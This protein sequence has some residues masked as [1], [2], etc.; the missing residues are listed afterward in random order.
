MATRVSPVQQ[1]TK[2]MK[3][4]TLFILFFIGILF[5]F[6]ETR[7]L[8]DHLKADAVQEYR[9]Q[10]IDPLA[11]PTM[12]KHGMNADNL[13]DAQHMSNIQTTEAPDDHLKFI[14]GKCPTCSNGINGEL[15]DPSEHVWR[16]EWTCY[17]VEDDRKWICYWAKIYHGVG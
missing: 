7:S 16:W 3:V 15:M 6:S 14:L 2:K 10:T 9:N 5:R 13:F 1:Q 17:W 12:Q 8:E 11:S 4:W